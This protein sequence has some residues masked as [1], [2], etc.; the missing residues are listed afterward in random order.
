[1]AFSMAFAFYAW[2]VLLNNYVIDVASFGGKEIGIL[3]SVREIPGF[4]AFGV[5][6]VLIFMRQQSLAIISLL[7]MSIGIISTGYCSSAWGLYFATIVMSLGF[8][9]LET[10]LQSLQLLWLKK[11]EAP[12]IMGRVVSVKN[13]GMTIT[14]VLMYIC[15]QWLDISYKLAYVL[16]GGIGIVLTIVAIIGFKKFQDDDGQQ[17]KLVFKRRYWLFYVLTFLSG[18]RRQIFVVFAS[19]LL[20]QKFGFT[21]ANIAMLHFVNALVSIYFG[22]KVGKL[23]ARIGERSSLILEYTGLLIL[24]ISYALVESQSVAVA[25]Y[26]VDHILFAMAIAV[27]TYFQKIADTEDLTSSAGVSFTINH[28]AAVFLPAVLGLVWVHNYSLVFFIAAGI[29]ALSLLAAFMVPRHPT[30]KQ[31]LRYLETNVSATIKS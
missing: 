16:F 10:V 15:F 6:Y 5:I 28:I 8:H 29:A 25:L 9:Y 13:L 31:Y 7:L 3:Q 21:M 14:F 19:F 27:K 18:A 23:I 1:M 17:K 12:I 20:V 2:V 4:L 26:I 30:P 24:F 22:Q 11:E